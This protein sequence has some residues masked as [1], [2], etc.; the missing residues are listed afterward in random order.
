MVEKAIDKSVTIP[1]LF[2]YIDY[3]NEMTLL[4]NDCFILE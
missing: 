2:K 4:L 1:L 3:E